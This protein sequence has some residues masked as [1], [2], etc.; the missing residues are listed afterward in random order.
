MFVGAVNFGRRTSLN[1]MCVFAPFAPTGHGFHL[2]KIK[3][4]LDMILWPNEYMK[5]CIK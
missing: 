5:S 4:A 2:S 3:D 1:K